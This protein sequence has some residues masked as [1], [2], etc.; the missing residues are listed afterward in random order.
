MSGALPS[1]V[2][3]GVLIDDLYQAFQPFHW[4]GCG[5]VAEH[6]ALPK[7]APGLEDCRT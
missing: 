1:A 4:T 3:S 5:R 2:A 6:S 7:P